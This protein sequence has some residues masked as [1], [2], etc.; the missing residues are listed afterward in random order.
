VHP[1][2]WSVDRVLFYVPLVNFPI[3]WYGLFFALGIYLS[4]KWLC[5]QLLVLKIIDPKALQSMIVTLVIAIIIGA[6]VGDILFY[7]DLRYIFYHPL[8]VLNLRAGGLASH[9]GFLGFLIG[10]FLVCRKSSLSSI[11]ML[12]YM[13]APA[14]LLAAFIRLG[15]L[16][17]QEI[18]GK[19]YQGF[20]SIIFT[21]PLDGSPITPRHP[22][23]LYEALCYALICIILYKVKMGSYQKTGLALICYF[24][25]RIFLEVFKQEQSIYTLPWHLSMGM[26]LSV[27]MVIA[28]LFL[29]IKKRKGELEKT[30]PKKQ[31]S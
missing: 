14:G 20:G 15:N 31:K 2:T 17:N 10:L 19:P 4:Q 27:P 21:S 7:Q 3:Y 22:V 30:H 29:L 18:L 8:E 11:Q 16:F 6:R 1:L 28:G 23:A 26:V 5:Q 12:C 24:G 9:G 13:S 25:S